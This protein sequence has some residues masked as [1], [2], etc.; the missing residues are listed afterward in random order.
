VLVNG[1]FTTVSTREA[2]TRSAQA[3]FL[4]DSFLDATA[5]DFAAG[6]SGVSD[7]R[8]N[9][10]AI[11]LALWDIIQD[12]NQ[13]RDGDGAITGQFILDAATNAR[14]GDLMN[15]YE[16]LAADLAVD[17]SETAFFLQTPTD[18]IGFHAQDFVFRQST[19]GI[20]VFITPEPGAGAFLI[21]S[22]VIACLVTRRRRTGH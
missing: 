9:L 17:T 10:A 5:D 11:Q 13:S 18:P 3:A 21:G 14:F 16:G 8:E 15:F 6:G 20:E 22:G 7:L 2:E 12:G 1:D 19:L 4:G